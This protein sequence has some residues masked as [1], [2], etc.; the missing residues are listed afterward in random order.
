MDNLLQQIGNFGF[1]MVV[2]IYLLVRVEGK[3]EHLSFSIN[4]LAKVIENLK[5]VG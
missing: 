4:E 2:S 1:P 3:L 5:G